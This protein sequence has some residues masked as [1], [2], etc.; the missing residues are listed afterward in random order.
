LHPTSPAQDVPKA[1][2]LRL[3]RFRM[4]MATYGVVTLA[5]LIL[6]RLGLGAMSAAQW[7]GFVGLAVVINVAL[8]ALFRSGANL[9]FADPSL[10]GVQIVVSALWGTLLVYAL[11]RARPLILMFYLPAFSFGMLRFNRPE[12]FGVVGILLGI[13]AGL[14]GL[15]YATARPGFHLEYEFFLFVFFA[16]LLS[17]FA[18]FGGFVSNLRRRLGAQ[19]HAL[20]AANDELRESHAKVKTLRGLLPICA[21]C[22]KIRD[23][24]GHWT[25]VESYVR[26]HSDAE[27]SHGICPDCIAKLYPGARLMGPGEEAGR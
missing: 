7:V 1:Q 20:Q 13:Y 9:R 25:Q 6:S 26:S 12:Y 16:L 24:A 4:A 11:P 23:D 21:S 27:F 19:K 2:S 3:A 10:T 5:A 8:Y 18:Y 17:W 22:K 15:E 14:L